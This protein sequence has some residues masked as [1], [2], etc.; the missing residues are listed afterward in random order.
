MTD[1]IPGNLIEHKLTKQHYRF[2]GKVTNSHLVVITTYNE[3]TPYT[4]SYGEL[5]Q[6]YDVVPEH[7]LVKGKRY[8]HSSGANGTIFEVQEIFTN[9]DTKLKVAFTWATYP[10]G[11]VYHTVIHENMWPNFDPI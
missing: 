1:F 2:V 7:R 10:S 11:N 4:I 6:Y 5:Y 3:H 9:P 8:E